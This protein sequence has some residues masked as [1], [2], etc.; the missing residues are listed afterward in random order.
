MWERKKK[1][2]K[3]I[4]SKKVIHQL[5]KNKAACQNE[6]GGSHCEM[7][8]VPDFDVIISEFEL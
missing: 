2:E 4:K 6:R 5:I 1:E 3:G 7:A 8:N